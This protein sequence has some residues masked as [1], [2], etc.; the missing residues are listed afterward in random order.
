MS[1]QIKCAGCGK[2]IKDGE[3]CLQESTLETDW[4]EKESP[5]RDATYWHWDCHMKEIANMAKKSR[6][7]VSRRREN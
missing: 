7:K 1:E 3:F 4:D 2:R 6:L 5:K